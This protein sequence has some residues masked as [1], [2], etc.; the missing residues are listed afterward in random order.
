MSDVIAFPV[1]RRVQAPEPLWRE[2][3]GE[4]VHEERLDREERIVDVAGR[5]GIAPQYL[6]EIERGRK[7]ASSEVLGAVAGALDL[8]MSEVT[9][10]VASRLSRGAVVLA[11]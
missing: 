7:D 2:A 1:T 11:A 9:H 8:T 6:S 5:A 10:R 3:L 4:V